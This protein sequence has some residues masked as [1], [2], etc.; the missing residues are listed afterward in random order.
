[1]RDT[2]EALGLPYRI[3]GFDSDMSEVINYAKAADAWMKAG[4][5]AAVAQAL[6]IAQPGGGL[7]ARAGRHSGAIAIGDD[8]VSSKAS[9]TSSTTSASARSTRSPRARTASA[10]STSSAASRA[11]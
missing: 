9:A 7:T 3:F 6:K 5:R 4:G 10:C 1:M 8:D 11:T 2:L